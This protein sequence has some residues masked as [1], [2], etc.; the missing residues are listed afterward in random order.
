MISISSFLLSRIF[1]SSG[2]MSVF[3]ENGNRGMQRGKEDKEREEKSPTICPSCMFCIHLVSY[4]KEGRRSEG[5]WDQEQDEEH[6]L[7]DSRTLTQYLESHG[8]KT[9]NSSALPS[10]LK[11]CLFLVKWPH[12]INHVS[13]TFQFYFSVSS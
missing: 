13:F 5:R 8:S 12:P 4:E 7:E 6:I 11:H 3:E 2:A 1:T 9:K 10:C